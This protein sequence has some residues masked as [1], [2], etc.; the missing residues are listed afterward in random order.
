MRERRARLEALLAGAPQVL[1]PLAA[2]GATDSWKDLAA[3]RAQSRAHGVE[4]Y[5]EG[6]D[7]GY[8]TGRER[9]AWWK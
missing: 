5:V 6:S 9:G 1:K 7:S 2:R 8:G 4:A 3:L